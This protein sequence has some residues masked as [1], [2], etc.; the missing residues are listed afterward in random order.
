MDN[1]LL[2]ICDEMASGDEFITFKQIF[3]RYYGVK[4]PKLDG[5]NNYETLRKRL[6]R[7]NQKYHF[8]EYKQKGNLREGFKYKKLSKYFYKN[9]EEKTTLGKLQG[10][11][12]ELFKTGGLQML[13]DG[14]S[15]MNTLLNLNGYQN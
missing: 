8:I 4:N 1:R 13:F 10:N 14:E 6:N 11:E 3:E 5:D 2:E 9:K 15:Q 12:R 7:D